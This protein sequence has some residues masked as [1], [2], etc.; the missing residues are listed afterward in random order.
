MELLF[1]LT[2][3]HYIGDFP[4]QGDFL[5]T[6]KGKFDYLLFSHALIWAGVICAVLGYFNAFAWWKVLFLLIGH[7]LIDRW[8]ARKEDKTNALTKD[9][10]IDQALHAVQIITV[11]VL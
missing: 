8:K 1:A 7:I 5:G 11:A 6:M 10:W 2:V 9:L 4:L 3:A